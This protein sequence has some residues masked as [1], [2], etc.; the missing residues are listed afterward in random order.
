M[1]G[2]AAVGQ[3]ATKAKAS[4]AKPDT[5]QSSFNIEEIVAG[6]RAALESAE[7]DEERDVLNEQLATLRPFV[8][9]SKKRPLTDEEQS[10]VDEIGRALLAQAEGAAKGEVQADMAQ[11]IAY[12]KDQQAA[13]DA[14]E[15]LAEL[16]RDLAAKADIAA[17]R[18]HEVDQFAIAARAHV[19]EIQKEARKLEGESK[20]AEADRAAI[21]KRALEIAREEAAVEAARDAALVEVQ[22][23]GKT[24][25]ERI[26][27]QKV[28]ADASK[29]LKDLSLE[30][31]T[32]AEDDARA[33]QFISGAADRL[34]EIADEEAAIRAEGPRLEAERDAALQA[35]TDAELA[36]GMA[37][38]PEAKVPRKRARA[39]P[40]REDSARQQQIEI[41][42]EALNPLSTN[43]KRALFEMGQAQQ[44]Q[45]Q[46]APPQYISPWT[47]NSIMAPVNQGASTIPIL[48]GVLKAKLGSIGTNKQGNPPNKK[49]LFALIQKHGLA[50]E[51][52]D[53]V[54]AAGR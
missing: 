28:A 16:E 45:A 52:A 44:G 1:R 15:V 17:R 40:N 14:R 49:Q 53:A 50:Q 33:D 38:A 7:S 36:L 3:L 29:D 43:I 22:T 12:N 41:L 30:E 46:A 25:K 47:A 6:L 31:K 35:A 8:L 21:A 18:A 27:L 23:A 5:P 9:L 32:L 48:K 26:A 11:R 13:S 51:L 24:V 19:P 4:K 34:R 42:E 20:R 37:P 39:I 54:A 2:D 10:I